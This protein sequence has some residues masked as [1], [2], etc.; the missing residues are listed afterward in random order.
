MRIR[1]RGQLQTPP[2]D[3]DF[4]YRDYLE[5]QGVLSYMPT[6]EA[7]LLPGNEGNPISP[8]IYSFKDKA[9]DSLF[10]ASFPIPRLPYWR[11]CC[12]VCM[13][14]CPIQSNK[15][16]EIPARHMSLLYPV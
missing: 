1:L 3:E 11:V 8:A 5:R 7:T 9:L 2:Q 4:S 12:L 10:I 6:S 14:A 15:H 16:F 13:A